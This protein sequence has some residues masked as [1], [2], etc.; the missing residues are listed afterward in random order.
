MS[1]VAVTGPGLNPS[2]AVSTR[3][4]V[5]L[6]QPGLST[7]ALGAVQTPKE[8]RQGGLLS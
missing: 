5:S 1:Q 2:R 3:L 8:K 4:A 6:M 7:V